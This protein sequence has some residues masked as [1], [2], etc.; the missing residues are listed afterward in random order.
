MW[1]PLSTGDYQGIVAESMVYPTYDG[2]LIH[3]YHARPIDAGPL[4]GLV[5]AHHI[6]GWDDFTLETA[7]RLAHFGY[8][9]LVPDQYCRYGHG[10]VDNV[11]AIVRAAGG[12]DDRDV[13]GDLSS[14]M[15][16]L[17]ALPTSNGKVGIAGPCSG[18]RASVLTACR[19]PGGFD[20]VVDLWG[21]RMLPT[22]DQLTER[23][24]VA[25]IEYVK[26]LDAPL[27]G[28]FGNDDANPTPADVDA[29]EAE[30]VRHGKN[31]E[32]HRF[33]GAGHGF[34]YYHLERYRWQQAMEGWQI[35]TRFL[36]DT[37]VAG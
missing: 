4:P 34:F 3:A 29:L 28:L 2:T 17:R 9:V 18:G 19:T 15:T 12:T 37:L 7:R 25:P 22:P 31:Y 23:I 32:F 8:S 10:D 27:L 6:S 24:P 30:L 5:F 16:Y 13:V 26:D 14:A 36:H 21:G 20:A 1:R 11:A 35:L 33:D